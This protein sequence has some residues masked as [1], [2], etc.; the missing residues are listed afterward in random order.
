[1]PKDLST[2]ETWTKPKEARTPPHNTGQTLRA[3]LPTS[4]DAPQGAVTRECKACAMSC[5]M[6]EELDKDLLTG[7]ILHADLIEP[8]GILASGTAEKLGEGQLQFR[9]RW[10]HSG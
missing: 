7:R 10:D 6:P 1:M 4:G 9:P 3:R 8:P 2:D 5:V